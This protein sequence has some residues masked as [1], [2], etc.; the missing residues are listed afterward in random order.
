MSR[1]RYE[2]MNACIRKCKYNVCKI[3]VF[4]NTYLVYC[5]YVCTYIIDIRPFVELKFGKNSGTIFIC[6]HS[7]RL[8]LWIEYKICHFDPFCIVFPGICAHAHTHIYICLYK[9][10]CAHFHPNRCLKHLHP[11]Y[12]ISSTNH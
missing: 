2:F 5:T 10:V 4:L 6:F 11:F 1:S 8:H 12:N 3:F 7:L 9:G